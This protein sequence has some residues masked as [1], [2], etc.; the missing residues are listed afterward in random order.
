MAVN[1]HEPLRT[2]RP[3]W[4]ERETVDPERVGFTY[5][6]PSDTLFVDF[7]GRPRPAVSV[8]ENVG[9]GEVDVYLRV[10][11]VSEEVVGLQI[12]GVLAATDRPAWLHDALVVAN[13]A[14]AD[15]DDAGVTHRGA[16]GTTI[17][18]GTVLDAIF[19]AIVPV[20]AS[21]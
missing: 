15:T 3:R 8:P 14:E 1:H 9:L 16:N 13:V 10:E 20:T 11:P 17:E 4:P 12:E 18:K 19:D 2:F 21:G 5:D 6:R 7:L